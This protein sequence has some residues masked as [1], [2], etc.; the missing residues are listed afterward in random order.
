MLT[1]R[2][3]LDR[4]FVEA[5]N[6]AI[7]LLEE[8]VTMFKYLQLWLYSD[9]IFE[10]EETLDAIKWETLLDIYGWWPFFSFRKRRSRREKAD[11]GTCQCL[12]R[13]T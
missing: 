13:V 5:T 3:H 4:R 1:V 12:P 8:D 10:A 7:E 11:L 6:Q 9:S 2:L